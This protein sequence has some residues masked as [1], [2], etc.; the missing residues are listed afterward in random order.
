MHRK[1]FRSLFLVG[2]IGLMFSGVSRA[3]L[4]SGCGTCQG[5]TYLLTY[6]PTKTVSSIGV[7]IYDVFLTIDPSG[8]TGGGSYINAVAIKIASD[9]GATG[10]VIIAPGG[11]GNWT[12]V[13]GG[14]N[15]SGCSGAGAGFICASDG[16]TAPVPT[17]AGTTY[18]WEFNYATSKSLLTGNLA[19]SIKVDYVNG[20]GGKV[21]ALV[22]EDITLQQQVPDGGM[23]LMLLGG[24]LVGLE[25]L[26]RRFRS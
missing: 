25:T 4:L 20:T 13:D 18:I 11:A 15:A 5:S 14:L 12:E 7:S 3:D 9:N 23:A 1:V 16:H 6:D 8:Y 26:R 10:S 22:S 19:S 2:V 24:A 21:G 17:A